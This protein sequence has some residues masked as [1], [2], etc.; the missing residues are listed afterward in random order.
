MIE[1]FPGLGDSGR[2]DGGPADTCENGSQWGRCVVLG[3]G[4][5]LMCAVREASW[6]RSQVFMLR[7]IGYSSCGF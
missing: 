3:S 4:S 1:N 7:A 5:V 6:R 2:L